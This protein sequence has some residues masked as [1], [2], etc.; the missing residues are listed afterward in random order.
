MVAP[1][2]TVTV[3]AETAVAD[4]TPRKAEPAK[5]MADKTSKSPAPAAPSPPSAPLPTVIAAE[6]AAAA[7]G[8]VVDHPSMQG[9]LGAVVSAE[10]R[11]DRAEASLNRSRESAPTGSGQVA[12]TEPSMAVGAALAKSPASAGSAPRGMQR[13][14]KLPKEE[15][16]SL[17]SPC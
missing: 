16:F 11:S 17:C 7:P 15:M 4:T 9:T 5:A 14:C 2:P 8:P 10:S 12:A 6:V 3:R 13:Y 1:L